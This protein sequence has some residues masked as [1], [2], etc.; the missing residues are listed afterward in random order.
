MLC[1]ISADERKILEQKQKDFTEIV[2]QELAHHFSFHCGPTLVCD[3]RRTSLH[4]PHRI[5]YLYISCLVRPPTIPYVLPVPPGCAP[6]AVRY[7]RLCP[8][9]PSAAPPG[10]RIPVSTTRTVKS[11]PVIVAAGVVVI[12]DDAHSDCCNIVLLCSPR[13]RSLRESNSQGVV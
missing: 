8:I 2:C 1:R 12:V 5:P 11:S 13:P 9:K 4:L 3:V 7:K 6:V 10:L